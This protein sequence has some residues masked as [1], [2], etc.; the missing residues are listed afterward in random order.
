MNTTDNESLAFARSKR[1]M[2]LKMGDSRNILIW[3]RKVAEI[4]RTMSTTTTALDKLV[5]KV[6]AFRT[7]NEMRAAM[8]NG[9]CPTLNGGKAAAKLCGIVR[10]NGYKAFRLGVVA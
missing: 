8:G 7:W 6:T 1:D 3:T 2:A 10:Q 4:I 5:S 9:Y